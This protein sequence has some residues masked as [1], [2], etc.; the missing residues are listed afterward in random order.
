MSQ[1]LVNYK[2]AYFFLNRSQSLKLKISG[3]VKVGAYKDRGWKA[4]APVFAFNCPD[5]GIVASCPY[6]Y[7]QR[8]EC[9]QCMTEAKKKKD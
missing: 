8:L 3:K 6:G 1:E 9:P 5:H 7:N 4:E 2:R